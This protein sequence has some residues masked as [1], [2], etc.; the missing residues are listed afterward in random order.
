MRKTLPYFIVLVVAVGV[1]AQSRSGRGIS[2]AVFQ[3]GLGGYVG[4]VDT[5]IKTSDSTN[6]YGTLE[7]VLWNTDDPVGTGQDTYGLI[8]FEDIFGSGEGQVPLD[9]GIVSATFSYEEIDGTRGGPMREVLVDWDESV[10]YDTFGP[11]PG[12]QSSDRGQTLIAQAWAGSGN[13]TLTPWD[14]NV[15]ESII[16]WQQDPTT[17]RGWIVQ[18][19]GSPSYGQI[20]SSE[21]ADDESVRPL[22]TVVYNTTGFPVLIRKPYLQ[23]PTQT[24]MTIVWRT[25]LPSTSRVILGDAPNSLKLEFNDSQLVIDHAVTV[26]GLSPDT[27]YFYA[28]GTLDSILDGANAQTYFDTV[29]PDGTQAQCTIWATGDAGRNSLEQ[30]Q[31][32]D[33]MIKMLGT[34]TP[35]L[36]LNIGD[37]A[38]NYCSSGELTSNMFSVYEEVLRHT[39]ILPTMGSHEAQ[40]NNL[41]TG[42]G[43]YFDAFHLPTLGECGGAPSGSE[44]YFSIDYG[45]VH[46]ICVTALEEVVQG[47][48]MVQWLEEDLLSTDANW[49][50]AF[51]N[52]A[53]YSAGPHYSNIDAKMIS[54]R[55]IVVPVLED[56]GVDLVLGG[57]S[58]NYERSFLVDGA[59]DTPTTAEGH[60][61]DTGDGRPSGDGPY[62]KPPNMTPH[63]GTVYVV[64]GHGSGGSFS[65]THPLMGFGSGAGSEAGSCV[66]K[67]VDNSLFFYN[68]QASGQITDEFVIKKQVLAD[69]DSDG[70]VGIN[71]L[72]ILIGT[73][74][75]CQGECPA[76]LNGDGIVNVLDLLQL[77][78]GWS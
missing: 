4:T 46:V 6:S 52:H 38:Y 15:R 58:H 3:D 9:A 70:I 23:M 21:F 7:Y 13:G 35:D 69:I 36:M 1:F 24:S 76:D 43:P 29:P 73:W 50:V 42:A 41:N 16:R 17:N 37:V 45:G 22:L 2:S 40:N 28:V 75:D 47:A 60:I 72:L 53:P 74:G 54:M 39:T 44:A 14:I 62:I 32:R 49:V 34:D 67:I 18:A 25:D 27:R 71:D 11:S 19:Y 77:I 78:A 65:G 57:Y 12:V 8:R 51:F 61:I 10:T 33:A 26:T 59:Y 66:I 48:P 20:Y 31:V 5:F 30:H 56:F 63:N 64:A 55:E 68:I